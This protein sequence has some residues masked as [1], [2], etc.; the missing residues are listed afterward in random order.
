MP[1]MTIRNEHMGTSAQVNI[2]W[3]GTM[4]YWT[5]QRV[6]RR[7]LGKRFTPPPGFPLPG[8]LGESGPQRPPEFPG[9]E[10]S[11]EGAEGGG[12][13]AKP[14]PLEIGE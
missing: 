14:R 8:L 9:W 13:R 5:K 4:S 10:F 1:R 11:F 6:R 12:V 3:D 2:P 7:L